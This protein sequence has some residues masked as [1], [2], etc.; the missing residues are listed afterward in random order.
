DSTHRGS[1]IERKKPNRNDENNDSIIV[2]FLNKKNES[3]V[4]YVSFGSESFLS[5]VEM[6]EIARGLEFSNVNFIWVIRFP[7]GSK[8]NIEEALPQG[9]LEKVK[10]RGMVVDGWASQAKILEHSSTGGFLSH[11]GWS[12]SLLMQDF[13]WKLVLHWRF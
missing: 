6:E 1:L 5:K 2:E 4:V 8:D 11:C 9:F 10:E 12:S 13:V 7:Q 3:S